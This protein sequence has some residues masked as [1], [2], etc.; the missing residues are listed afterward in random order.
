MVFVG[1]CSNLDILFSFLW[2]LFFKQKPLIHR[3]EPR[4]SRLNRYLFQTQLFTFFIQVPGR[5][6]AIQAYSCLLIGSD[7]TSISPSEPFSEILFRL[8][9]DPVRVSADVSNSV[10]RAAVLCE[11]VKLRMLDDLVGSNGA[12]D[13]LF[14]RL[15]HYSIEG[16][17]NPFA[18]ILGEMPQLK[19]DSVNLVDHATIGEISRGHYTTE[20]L[21]SDNLQQWSILQLF[22]AAL[23]DVALFGYSETRVRDFC[24]SVRLFSSITLAVPGIH[25]LL[26]VYRRCC[27][28][29]EAFV[30]GLYE[31]SIVSSQQITLSPLSPFLDKLLWKSLSAEEVGK[32]EGE[33]ISVLGQDA[34]LSEPLG[35]T[36]LISLEMLGHDGRILVLEE[37]MRITSLLLG[38]PVP[39]CIVARLLLA[40]CTFFSF[41]HQRARL[42]KPDSVQ[43][44]DHVFELKILS[45]RWQTLRRMKPF[46][47]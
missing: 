43:F 34:P 6:E 21:S 4:N 47:F 45:T 3:D 10:F 27:H 20:P 12:I 15:N 33:V 24:Q 37:L 39:I 1:S 35:V 29:T 28:H 18:E 9:T 36:V 23:T 8:V 13:S 30:M 2:L 5:P 26:H 44:Q 38:E 42:L 41:Y 14:D 25:V 40:F 19:A 32:F 31:Q 22:F 11:T 7:A 46:T 16:Q 17:S